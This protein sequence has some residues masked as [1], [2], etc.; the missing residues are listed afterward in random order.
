MLKNMFYEGLRSELKDITGFLFDK[1]PNFDDLR[2]EVRIKEEEMNQRKK[3]RKTERIQAVSA[4]EDLQE[5]KAMIQ[6][7]NRDVSEMKTRVYTRDED[8]YGEKSQTSQYLKE[9]R[10]RGQSYKK[11]Q[12]KGR[13]SDEDVICYRC[14][15]P[16]HLK[17][18]C[19]VRLDH[20]SDQD[21]NT[22]GPTARRSR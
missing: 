19:R 6:N 2:H 14:G 12:R 10:G 4:N 11:G 21:L 22:K 18:G 1:I 7:L 15:Q 5:I 9:N 16:G 13:Q 8:T 20:K 3:S 17:Y